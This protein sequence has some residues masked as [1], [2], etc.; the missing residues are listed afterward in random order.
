FARNTGLARTRGTLLSSNF[1]YYSLADWHRYVAVGARAKGVWGC[2]GPRDKKYW[3]NRQR[4]LCAAPNLCAAF[5]ILV[6]ASA[7]A[8]SRPGYSGNDS[9]HAALKLRAP[10]WQAPKER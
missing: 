6:V 10:G 5:C 7:D 2:L 8:S 3:L 4:N 1:R 9:A